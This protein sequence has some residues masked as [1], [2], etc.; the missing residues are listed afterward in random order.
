VQYLDRRNLN[1]GGSWLL[2]RNVLFCMCEDMGTLY[3]MSYD[4][5]IFFNNRWGVSP[6][7][8]LLSALGTRGY[9]AFYYNAMVINRYMC[10]L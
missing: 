1:K 7:D 6:Y 9:I 2:H 4:V 3:S 5:F 10:D 8:V